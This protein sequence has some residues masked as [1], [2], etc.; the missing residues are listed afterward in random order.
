MLKSKSPGINN[1][2]VSLYDISTTQVHGTEW[3]PPANCVGH[4]SSS[5]KSVLLLCITNDTMKK[6]VNSRVY[7]MH[8]VHCTIE[9]GLTGVKMSS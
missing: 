9:E 8:V 6:G 3:M 7:N 4:S 2:A 5:L 1:I